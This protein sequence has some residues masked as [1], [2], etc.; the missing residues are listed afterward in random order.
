MSDSDLQFPRGFT[1]GASTSSY[2]IEGGNVHS[3]WWRWEQSGAAPGGPSAGACDSWNRWRED[4]ALCKE[5][6]LSAYR[7]SC[8][9]ARIE[10]MPGAFDHEALERYA[11]MLATAKAEGLETMLVLWHF[12]L[13]TWFVDRGGWLESDAP[14]LFERYAEEVAEAVAPHVDHWATMNEANTF[15]GKGW[16]DGDWPPVRRNDWIG[17]WRVFMQLAKAHRLARNAIKRVVGEDTPVGL[18]HLFSWVH[19]ADGVGPLAA[20]AHARWD[21]FVNVA[22]PDMVR[23]EIDWLGV[24]YYFDTP[25]DV[26]TLRD[27]STRPRTEM[28]WRVEPRGLYEAIR[29][30]ADRYKV[31][32][33]VTEN[34]IADAADAQRGR[35]ILD[36]LAWLHRALDE[37]VDV[38]G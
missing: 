35:F 23:H 9:W 32:L 1:W 30:A 18:T 25:V 17:G 33:I 36:H 4:I 16:I 26:F 22:F 5:L 2:Q 13:P 21:F 27:E 11:L 28:G 15:V 20:F 29:M 19:P 6:G 10:P 24:Q 34:G 3:D 38:R 8:E 12:T 7:I 37:G 31:P 14:Q